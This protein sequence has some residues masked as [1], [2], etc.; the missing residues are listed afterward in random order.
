[1]KNKFLEGLLIGVFGAFVLF[2]LVFATTLHYAED[3]DE[4]VSAQEQADNNTEKD[5]AGA[6]AV[7]DNQPA[8]NKDE[9]TDKK[10]EEKAEPLSDREF[11]EKKEYIQ[12]IIDEYF[13]WEQDKEAAQTAE[14]RAMLESLNDPYSCYYT[15]EEYAQLM[16]SSSGIYCGIGALVQQNASTGIISI[17]KPFVDGPA[18]NAGVLPNDIIFAV[19]E[20][21]VTGIDLNNVVARMKGEPDTEVKVTV[22]REGE[23]IDIVITRGTVEVPTVEYEMLDNNIGYIY[24]MEFDEVTGE[25][26]I[27][28]IEEFEEQGME[29]LIVDVRDN[30]GGLLNIVCDM[31]DR[32]L[33]EGKIVYTEDKYGNVKTEYSTAAEEFNLPMVVLINGSSASAAE[34]F[35]GVV[36]DYDKAVIVGTQSFGKGIVQYVIPVYDGSGVKVTT[37]K[38]FTAMG[39]DIH[40][41]GITPDVVVELDEELKTLASIPKDKDNQL[42]AAIEILLGKING[43]QQEAA[44]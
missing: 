10:E 11:A 30:P 7:T 31:L 33:P 17:V 3:K 19:D 27:A 20:E 4:K 25:Q 29:G 32:L 40:G 41:K 38:Y 24:I 39:Q 13:L 22:Y 15:P 5:T 16:E 35:A 23:Y 6:D 34:I 42:A 2:M 44:Q 36:Q 21:E 9:S 1:M 18:Y 26:F 28:A 12:K 8:D 14:L 43:G 37:S